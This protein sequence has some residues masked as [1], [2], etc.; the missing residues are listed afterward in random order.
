MNTLEMPNQLTSTQDKDMIISNPYVVGNPVTGQ[1]FVGRDDIMLRF[2]E[3]WNSSLL[4]PIVLHGHR[5]SGKTSILRNLQTRFHHDQVIDFNM[6]RVSYVDS[7]G[8]LLYSLALAI[9]NIFP[10]GIIP[11]RDDFLNQ[12]PFTSF[13]QQLQKLYP[14][15]NGKRLIVAIDEF[16]IIEEL[17]QAGAIESRTPVFLHSL[18]KKY[19]WF[20]LLF[21]GLHT[22]QE[23]NQKYWSEFLD[24]TYHI[25]VGLLSLNATTQL[26]NKP[27][28]DFNLDYNQDAIDLIYSSTGGQPYLIQIICENLITRCND[29][30]QLG[31]DRP[32]I[33]TRE[34]VMAILS[35][36]EFYRDGRPYF[37]GVW[38]QSKQTNNGISILQALCTAPI[39]VEQLVSQTNFSLTQLQPSLNILI[40]HGVLF[41]QD[42]QY[43]YKIELMRRW[44]E[45]QKI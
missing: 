14:H 29:R 7:T 24:S 22:L 21:V 44:V 19:P 23:M 27:S 34:D 32:N 42:N 8:E 28:S 3:L 4:P 20:T 37:I 39:S 12:D 15:L 16:E 31:V 2:E 13:D 26:I 18:V 38:E 36:P 25:H 6:Q 45:A 5:R 33:V 30:I 9:H 11:N 43:H 40:E 10:T 35:T 41:L 17:I 1:I